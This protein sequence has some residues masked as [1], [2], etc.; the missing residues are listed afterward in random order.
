MLITAKLRDVS[1]NVE[2]APECLD[3]KNIH[4]PIPPKSVVSCVIEM[5]EI[6]KLND[7]GKQWLK[8][9]INKADVT[10]Y[11]HVPEVVSCQT[12]DEEDGSAD[13]Y[14]D[15]DELHEDCRIVS[16]FFWQKKK[17]SST[18]NYQILGSFLLYFV[19]YFFYFRHGFPLIELFII[20][21]PFH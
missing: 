16:I 11:E 6:V 15:F 3:Y 9:V 14:V 21:Q 18:F 12:S 1:S 2:I 17:N 8:T 20:S 13:E 5:Y 10:P 19:T 4:T 7:F